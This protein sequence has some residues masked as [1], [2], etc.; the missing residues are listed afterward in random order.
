MAIDRPLEEGVAPAEGSCQALEEAE[1]TPQGLGKQGDAGAAGGVPLPA[2][3]LGS[4][5]GS[6]N[7]ATL[8]REAKARAEPEVTTVAGIEAS[9]GEVATES[10]RGRG[11]PKGSKNR[12]IWSGKPKC[13][14]CVLLQSVAQDGSRASRTSRRRGLK[15]TAQQGSISTNFWQDCLRAQYPS[16]CEWT[17]LT[18]NS[19]LFNK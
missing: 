15:A 10:R 9:G 6:R 13:R 12:K 11:R 17:S 4:P 19:N 1:R 5:K 16:A 7:R 8:E 14:G 3:R 2:H 18:G